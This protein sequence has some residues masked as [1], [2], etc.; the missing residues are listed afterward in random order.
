MPEV[1]AARGAHDL[2]ANHPVSRVGLLVDRVL[3]GRRVEGRPA[4]ARVVLRLRA[5][6]LGPATGAAIRARLEDVVVLAG[7]RRLGALL[8]QDA[9]LLGGELGPPLLFCFLDLLHALQSCGPA[10]RYRLTVAM[11]S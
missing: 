7:E 6:D 9:V 2:G 1:T 3:A 4:A 8:P 5:E 11:F 10:I